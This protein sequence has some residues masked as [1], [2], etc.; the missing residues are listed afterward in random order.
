MF[1]IRSKNVRMGF[2]VI[3]CLLFVLPVGWIL[4]M[5]LEGEKPAVNLDLPYPAIGSDRDIPLSVADARSGLR[6]IWVG[7]VRND[8]EFVFFEKDFS[9]GNFFGFGKVRKESFNIRIRPREKGITDGK[10]LLR[11]IV[12]DLSWRRWWNGNKTLIEKEISVDTRAPAVDVLSNVH[13]IIQGGASFVIYKLSEPCSENGVLVGDNFFPAYS[14]QKAFGSQYPDCLMAFFA[15]GHKQ[16]RDTEIVIKAVDHAGNITRRNFR[17]FV[18]KKRVKKDTINISDRFLSRKMPEFDVGSML[19]EISKGPPLPDQAEKFLTINRKLREANFRSFVELAKKT[20]PVFYWDSKRFLSLPK[21]KRMA[22]FAEYREYKYGGR[23]IDRQFHMGVDQASVSNA[24]VLAGNRGKVLF[25]G[26][27]GIYGR[28]IVIDHG[29]GLLS[30]YAHLSR[31]DVDE[32]EVVS[33]KQTIGLTG[34][35]GL[36]G[37][38]HLHFSILLHNTF[39]NPME[40]WDPRWV[41]NNISKKINAVKKTGR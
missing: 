28:T 25:A 27:M 15:L 7:L 39:V 33:K 21:S 32:G 18:G 37:G 13:N 26:R 40:W 23:T 29:L 9:S 14:T 6:R 36:A 2:F 24:P 19:P 41:R 38:D 3:L 1:E 35:S 4:T 22:G 34:Q 17:I 16:D 31:F 10:A 5:K 12:T 11:V 8:R 30:I 20:E